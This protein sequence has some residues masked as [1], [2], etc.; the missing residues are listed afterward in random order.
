MYPCS[1]IVNRRDGML[2]VQRPENCKSE[3]GPK[4]RS[5]DRRKR[6]SGTSKNKNGDQEGR[7]R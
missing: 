7:I 1:D 4:S 2:G 3:T 6:R 5:R